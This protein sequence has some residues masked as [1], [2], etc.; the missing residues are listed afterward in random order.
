MSP[1]TRKERL[2]VAIGA[3][4]FIVAMLAFFNVVWSSSWAEAGVSITLCLLASGIYRLV[5]GRT[6]PRWR[7]APTNT[8][9]QDVP[10]TIATKSDER[11]G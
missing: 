11:H 10:P 1:T 7:G 9:L 4:A 6:G 8:Q 3:G 2:L 5:S